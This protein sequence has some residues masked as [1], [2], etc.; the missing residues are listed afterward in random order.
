MLCWL[1]D[2]FKGEDAPKSKANLSTPAEY[3]VMYL[4]KKSTSWDEDVEMDN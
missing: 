3:L 2:K 1:R 4:N